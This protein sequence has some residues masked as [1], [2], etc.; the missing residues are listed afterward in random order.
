MGEF[1]VYRTRVYAAPT[2]ETC[3][4]L[5]KIYVRIPGRP[6]REKWYCEV[7]GHTIPRSFIRKFRDCDVY[8][9]KPGLQLLDR[10]MR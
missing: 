5:K 8:E 1:K 9:P 3:K 6:I 2:C 4:H 7:L 10:H